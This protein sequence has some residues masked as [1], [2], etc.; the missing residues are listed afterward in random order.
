MSPDSESTS[1]LR[2]ESRTDQKPKPQLEG[3]ERPDLQPGSSSQ[4]TA[5]LQSGSEPDVKPVSG[6][7]LNPE[8]GLDQTRNLKPRFR[9]VGTTETRSKTKEVPVEPA[10]EKQPRSGS[11]KTK[12]LQT[13]STLDLQTHSGSQE[14]KA[15]E[16]KTRSGSEV[17]GSGSG[18]RLKYKSHEGQDPRPGLGSNQTI[19]QMDSR[20]VETRSLLS[21]FRSVLKT[22]PNEEPTSGSDVKTGSRPEDTRTQH[23]GSRSKVSV[24][25][26]FWFRA[27]IRGAFKSQS[28]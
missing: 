2:A 6:S 10:S 14:T 13:G 26:S 22:S 24:S 4:Q 25:K 1:D 21:R 18:L 5:E 15:P 19:N 17:P 12:D 8:F 16:L 3:P 11:E 7:H 28:S 23:S 9:S 20:P 27:A